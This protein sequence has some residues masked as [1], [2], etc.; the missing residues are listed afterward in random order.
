M[1]EDFWPISPMGRSMFDVM[2]KLFSEQ[3]LDALQISSYLPY[4]SLDA[5]EVP[6][7][8]RFRRDSPWIFNFQARF[9]KSTSLLSFLCEPEISES[10]VN[11]AITVEMASDQKARNGGGLSAMLLHYAWYP[12]SGVS[13][14]GEFTEL[15]GEL[16]NLVD[17]DRF[18]EGMFSKPTSWKGTPP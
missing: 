14:R 5:T 15:G 2:H 3:G 16:Q 13:Y 4:Y 17:I 10:E 7:L 1:L 9:W 12:I 6:N 8:F 11:S 18:V